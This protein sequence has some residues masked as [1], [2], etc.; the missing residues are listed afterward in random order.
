MTLF[1]AI[2][3]RVSQLS[4]RICN[5]WYNPPFFALA[6]HSGL[7]HRNVDGRV[8]ALT[9]HADERSYIAYRMVKIP[10]LIQGRLILSLRQKFVH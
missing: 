5:N 2:T 7:E 4:A 6:F 9:P 1:F 3:R 10:T 8:S